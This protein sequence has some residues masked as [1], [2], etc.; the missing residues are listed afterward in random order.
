MVVELFIA[1]RP[2]L[3]LRLFTK[4]TFLNATVLGYV[5]VIALFGAEFMMPIFL[6]AIRGKTALETG[7]ILLPMAVTSGSAT[8]IAGRLYDRF[9]P[10]P[11]VG[12]GF[13]MLIINTWQLSQIKADTPI[14]T[15]MILLALRGLAVGS[16]VQTTFITGLSVVPLK[17]IA[18]GSSL[19]NATRNVVQSIGVAILATVLTSALSPQ[20][21]AFQQQFQEAPPKIGAAPVAICTP[22]PASVLVATNGGFNAGSAQPSASLVQI[23]GQACKENIIGFE[24]AYTVTFYAAIVALGL[25]LM[26]PGWPLKFAG[27]RAADS[28]PVAGH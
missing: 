19:T 9:G 17:D 3:D 10:R 8:I 22:Q 4:R 5:S 2:L 20:I 23:L 28:P 27:R 25:G 6:Q 14:S 16:T 18:R 1:K 12:F 21:A 13:L 7:L 15:I 24:R 11:L 26:L